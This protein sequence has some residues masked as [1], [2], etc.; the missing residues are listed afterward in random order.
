ME[1]G[2][3]AA[4]CAD[5]KQNQQALSEALT[6]N[7][8]RLEGELYAQ[9]QTFK[10]L[11]DTLKVVD[12]TLKSHMGESTGKSVSRVYVDE[13]F[14]EVVRAD[15]VALLKKHCADHCAKVKVEVTANSSS[16]Q[17]LNAQVEK[18]SADLDEVL[19]GTNGNFKTFSGKLD[20]YQGKLADLQQKAV[21]LGS[22]LSCL[23]QK[24]EAIIEQLKSVSGKVAQAD[25]RYETLEAV[26]FKIVDAL[27]TAGV[28]ES[29]LIALMDL[30]G[31]I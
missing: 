31:E 8:K 17:T 22:Q 18:T 19:R 14:R 24:Q 4:A 21:E 29:Q 2:D 16:L 28:D 9:K 10:G 13:T 12:A 11:D 26:L 23:K 7:L 3:L 27:E 25:L 30:I 15:N 20:G 1:V 5:V 6:A